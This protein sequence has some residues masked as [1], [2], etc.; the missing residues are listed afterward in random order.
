MDI[1][2][3]MYPNL[4]LFIQAILFLVFVALVRSFLT[5]PYSRVIEEREYI[6]QQNTEESIK[7]REEAQKYLEETKDIMEK[8]RKESSQ[9]IEQAK[10]EAEKIKAE[11]L[12]RIEAETQ[13]EILKAVEEIRISLEEEKRKL[14]EKIEEVA[15]L[16]TGKFLEEV[17]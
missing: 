8:G 4:T 3:A 15:E 1:Q 9:I 11:I 13:E 17:A 14:D 16:I 12:T 10:K 6:T 7:L 5:Q 2:Q